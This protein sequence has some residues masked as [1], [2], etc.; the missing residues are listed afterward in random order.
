MSEAG[1]RDRM[2]SWTQNIQRALLS[3]INIYETTTVHGQRVRGPGNNQLT[4]QPPWAYRE[5]PGDIVVRIMEEG[6]RRG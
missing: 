5:T 3:K 4:L 6:G 1:I 2:P